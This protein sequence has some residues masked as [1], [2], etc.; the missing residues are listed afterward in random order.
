MALDEKNNE[1]K[2]ELENNLENIQ[3]RCK[4]IANEWKEKGNSFVKLKDYKS[5]SELLIK[6]IL[7]I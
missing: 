4:K 5:A 1:N 3:E 7:F 2:P 6:Y